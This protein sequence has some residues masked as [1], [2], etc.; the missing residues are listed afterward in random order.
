M[1]EKKKS[2]FI[3]ALQ[4]VFLFLTGMYFFT[5]RDLKNTKNDSTADDIA[6]SPAAQ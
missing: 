1:I 5:E 2:I 6:L 4:T 3:R